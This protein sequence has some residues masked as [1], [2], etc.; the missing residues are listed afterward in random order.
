MASIFA[1]KRK[2]GNCWYV[3]YYIDG[4]VIQKR[5][6]K[7]KK[8][9]QQVAGEIEAK[10]ERKDANMEP[11]DCELK[12][13]F[14]EYMAF[15]E[16][17]DSPKYHRRNEITVRHFMDFL[18]KKHPRISRLSQLSLKLFEEY[19]TWRLGQSRNGGKPIK[20]RTVNL[21]ISALKTFFN[22]AMKWQYLHANPLTHV[23]YLKQD[24]SKK[25]RSLT[26]VEVQKVL[27]N[28]PEWFYPVLFT[29]LYTGMREGEV[30]HLEW[31]DVDLVKGVIHIQKK[32]FWTPKS[33]GR[34]IRE[35]DIALTEGLV[36]FLK[37]HKLKDKREDTWV[38]HNRDGEQ[39]APGLRKVFGRITE[40][41]GFPEVT[42]IH[43]TRHT[44][45]THLIKC[46]KDIAVAQAQL[47]HT[48]IRTT[49]KYA[50]MLTEYQTQAANMLDYGVEEKG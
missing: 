49:M 14:A 45:A 27:E 47:G 7:S 2:N 35:R 41:M 32:D 36:T 42:Q 19:M 48:D 26:A 30:I 31:N 1:R 15:T 18:E 9:A 24:D 6:G 46:C 25:I 11:R 4:K 37:M 22:K 28:S 16:N 40:K 50:D 21:E 12:K 44:Y 20:K 33:S 5:V 17:N 8:L 34:E 3:Q 43:S 13:F 38:F 23:E 10:Q 29:M 39:L